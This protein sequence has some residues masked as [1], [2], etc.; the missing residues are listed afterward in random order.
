MEVNTG[1]YTFG[2]RPLPRWRSHKF[3]LHL[4]Q[5][6]QVTVND[7]FLNRGIIPPQELKISLQPHLFPLITI[8]DFSC[9][10]SKSRYDA[11]W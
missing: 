5:R 4:E 6:L 2:A 9:H 10:F 8:L 11:A 3:H 1:H 7:R